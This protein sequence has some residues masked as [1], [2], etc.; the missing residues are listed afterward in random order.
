MRQ[1][2]SAAKTPKET[3][4]IYNWVKPKPVSRLEVSG[5]DSF[6]SISDSAF[7]W[8]NMPT[9]AIFTQQFSALHF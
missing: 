3:E 1:D 5:V 8:N 9:E 2:F 4:K 6:P 7:Q